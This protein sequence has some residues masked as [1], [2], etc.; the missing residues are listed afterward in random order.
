MT[1]SATHTQVTACLDLVFEGADW[2]VVG[3]CLGKLHQ[4]PVCREAWASAARLPSALGS[5][6]DLA[7]ACASSYCSELGEPKPIFCREKATG[8]PPLLVN[9]AELEAAILSKEAGLRDH[10][11]VIGRFA[12]T[13]IAVMASEAVR[14]SVS[15]KVDLPKGNHK[16]VELGDATL[17]VSVL[18]D[19][20][21]EI[22]GKRIS[23]RELRKRF[24]SAHSSDPDIQVVL[25][26]A[27]GIEHR[28]VVS[29]I[30]MAKAA[31]LSRLAIAA[32][33]D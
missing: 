16:E 15:V 25:K 19:G 7:N 26:A 14:E 5:V 9:F 4:K 22:D 12:A 6:P 10:P 13:L 31:G 28:Y 32:A 30:D 27:K 17:V 24:V 1:E 3:P 33:N 20:A 11:G 21:V 18:S 29:V 8:N 23:E 2:A